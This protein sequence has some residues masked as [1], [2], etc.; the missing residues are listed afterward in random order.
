MSMRAI[1][2]LAQQEQIVSTAAE[3]ARRLRDCLAGRAPAQPVE[4]GFAQLNQRVEAL[5]PSI[6]AARFCLLRNWTASARQLWVQNEVVH[7]RYQ[8]RH[9]ARMLDRIRRDYE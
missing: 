8:L 2:D 6:D 9:L 1:L 5:P 4:E 3:A 7:S